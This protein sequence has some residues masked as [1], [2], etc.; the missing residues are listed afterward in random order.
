MG[1]GKLI[2]ALA[3]I[4]VLFLAVLKN[5]SELQAQADVKAILSEKLNETM[6]AQ[7][8]DGQN[9]GITQLGAGLALLI[10]G[11]LIDNMVEVDVSDYILF[12]TFD[13]NAVL[14]DQKTNVVS[15]FILFGKVI[16]T[17][18]ALKND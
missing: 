2:L 15:G 16:P 6:L 11:S 14:M 8:S 7:L 4:A 10:G 1:K 5:P 17:K 18:S 3:L 12:S 13:A 9:D